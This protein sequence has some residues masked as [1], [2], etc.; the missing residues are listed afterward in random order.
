M[1]RFATAAALSL[2]TVAAQ[3]AGVNNP[4]QVGHWQAGAY[5]NDQTKL[6]SHCAASATYKSQI[7]MF[8]TVSRSMT[9][10]LA[11]T[12]SQWSVNKGDKIPVQFRFDGGS[13]FDETGVALLASPPLVEVPM[14]DTSQLIRAFRAASQMTATARGQTFAFRLDG[15]SKLLPA[16][17]TCV[18]TALLAETN[19]PNSSPS[20][21]SS[22]T[23]TDKTT[24]EEMQLATN[25]LLAAHLSNAHVISRADA[26]VQLASIGTVWKADDSAGA[27]KIVTAKQNQ[28]G[29]DLASELIANDA[30]TCQGKFASARSSEL[31]DNDVVYRASTSCGDSKGEHLLQYFITPWHKESFAIFAVAGSMPSTNGDN[32]GPSKEDI[33]KKAALI[34][35]H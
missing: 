16:L 34:A 7:T 8:V 4:F 25:F 14:P 12:H 18:R 3:A 10:S 15:T 2:L 9:W 17:V 29:L 1:R 22:T 31:V 26:P 24:I 5:V 32:A 11:F 35:V 28:S 30:K 19:R 6:F 27:V 20:A 21:S 13:P 23:Q 33:Y